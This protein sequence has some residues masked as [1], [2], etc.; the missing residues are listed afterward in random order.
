[1]NQKSGSLISIVEKHDKGQSCIRWLP[2]FDRLT[3]LAVVNFS[4]SERVDVDY[5]YLLWYGW[6]KRQV[7]PQIAIPCT[8]TFT[9]VVQHL[10]DYDTFKPQTHDRGRDRTEKILH[11][12][13]QSLERVEEDPDINTCRFAAE[14]GVAQLVVHLT[15]KDPNHIV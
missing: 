14:I 8:R 6:W 2:S 3:S 9:S 1:M 11:A 10:R 5:H 15:L 7:G 13:E 4:N 12:E